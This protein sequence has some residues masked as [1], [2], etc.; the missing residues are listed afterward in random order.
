[1]TMTAGWGKTPPFSAAPT[2]IQDVTLRITL[3][4]LADEAMA[5]GDG[6]VA[7]ILEVAVRAVD[8]RLSEA[9]SDMDTPA[10]PRL[11]TTLVCRN[12]R[13]NDRRTSVK[14]EPD[15]WDALERLAER[16]GTT[17]D[18]LC[19]RVADMYDGGNFTSALRLFILHGQTDTGRVGLG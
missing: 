3:R 5:R 7:S 11:R 8:A 16:L 14:L 19:S 10:A 4:R 18:T 13:L 15:Y 17:V 2:C 9:A 12:V 1:M 6:P